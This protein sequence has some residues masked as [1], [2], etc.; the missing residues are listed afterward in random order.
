[1]SSIRENVLD[2]IPFYRAYDKIRFNYDLIKELQTLSTG[3]VIHNLYIAS[4]M[5]EDDLTSM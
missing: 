2:N 5:L 4:P 3:I 1:M